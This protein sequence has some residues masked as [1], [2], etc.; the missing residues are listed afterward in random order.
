MGPRYRRNLPT[1]LLGAH[2]LVAQE[3]KE[4]LIVEEFHDLRI[5]ARHHKFLR[6]LTNDE[7]DETVSTVRCTSPYT[8]TAA[9]GHFNTVGHWRTF[10]FPPL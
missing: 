9:D 2:W 8:V 10:H 3:R 5:A 6:C 4:A 1:D 7:T